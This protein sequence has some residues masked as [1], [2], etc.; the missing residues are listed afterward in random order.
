MVCNTIFQWTIVRIYN[1]FVIVTEISSKESNHVELP[2]AN[3]QIKRDAKRLE[4]GR[5]LTLWIK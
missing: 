3:H 4:T 2:G 5:G 1:K